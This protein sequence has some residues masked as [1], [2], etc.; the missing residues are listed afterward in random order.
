MFKVLS[1]LV[2]EQKARRSSP[3]HKFS[4]TKQNLSSSDHRRAIEIPVCL[5][6]P[7]HGSHYKREAKKLSNQLRGGCGAFLS[8]LLLVQGFQAN[9][10]RT[11]PVVLRGRVNASVLVGR[12]RWD[13]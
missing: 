10:V 1:L 8:L 6:E 9:Y 11:V 2:A 12:I 3:G 7:G 13:E 5:G 4:C